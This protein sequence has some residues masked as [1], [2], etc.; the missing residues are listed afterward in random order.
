MKAIIWTKYGP[1]EVLKLQDIKNPIPKNNEILIQ[2]H[3]TTVYQGDCEMRNLKFPLYFKIP[4]RLLKGIRKPKGLAILGQELSGIVEEVGKDVKL[5][6]KGDQVFGAVNPLIGSGTY[7]EYTCQSEVGDDACF[8]SKPENMSFKEAATVPVG[9]LNALYFLRK[10]NIQSGQKVLLNGAGG[11]IG[12]IAIQ[13]TKKVYDAEVTAVDHTEKLEMLRTIGADHIVDYTQEDFTES[14]IK[15]DVIFDV[16][17]KASYGGSIKSLKHNGIFLLG[18]PTIARR[19]RGLLTKIVK[20]KKVIGGTVSYK[21]EDLLYL[22]ELIEAGKIKAVIDREYPLEEAV[23]AHKYVDTW[24][25]KGN[26]VL[27]VK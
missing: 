21:T 14:G 26:V 10:A 23:E 16:V 12:T 9:G 2:I 1:P 13:L 7:A 15:Y 8:V 22:K 11:S 20:G 3:S 4:I 27:T 17:G 6:K 19:V 25:K 18:N 5:F 24:Q